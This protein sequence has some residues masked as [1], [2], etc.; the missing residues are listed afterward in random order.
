MDRH[1]FRSSRYEIHYEEAGNQQAESDDGQ[2]YRSRARRFSI[3]EFCRYAACEHEEK[4]SEHDEI[5]ALNPSM[6]PE[7]QFAD[8][9]RTR[10]IAGAHPAFEGEGRNE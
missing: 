6:W 8:E 3:R 4:R 7:R 2:K 10:A 9:H 1:L 5:D